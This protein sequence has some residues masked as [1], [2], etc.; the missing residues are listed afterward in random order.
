MA[1]TKVKPV[2]WAIGGDEP[3]DLAEFKD[4]EQIVKEN[5]GLPAKGVYRMAVRRMYVKPNKNED[6]RI[7]VMLVIDEPKKSK[8][9]S[10][11]GYLVRDGFN[12]T[13][14]G[15]PFLKRFLK[16]LGLSWDD[17]YKRSKEQEDGDRRELIQIGGTK[18][19]SAASKPVYVN[20]LLKEK[21]ADDYNDEPYMDVVRYIP[22]DDD[23][24]DSDSGAD[25]ATDMGETNTNDDGG[26]DLSMD[27]LNAMKVKDLRTKAEEAGVKVKKIEAAGKDKA[28]LID[29][30]AK[31]LNLP[32]F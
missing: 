10:F 13:E 12:I 20:A 7:S 2:K 30:I 32:P 21:P 8:S 16:G 29:L 4:N 1:K 25:D 15:T 22:K 9:V 28:A 5:K 23:E 11:N 26:D 17:F 31:K 24:G 18:F 14:Q 6:D 19:G 3:E 27:A